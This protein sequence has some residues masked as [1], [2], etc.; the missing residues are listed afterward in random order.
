MLLDVGE[1]DDVDVDVALALIVDGNVVLED[2]MLNL[3]SRLWR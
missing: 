1:I 2:W 3:W